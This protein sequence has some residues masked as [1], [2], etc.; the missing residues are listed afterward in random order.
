MRKTTR[1]SPALPSEWKRRRSLLHSE[2]W[3]W[4]RWRVDTGLYQPVLLFST[5]W[6]Q[7]DGDEVTVQKGLTGERLGNGVCLV[8]WL[9]WGGDGGDWNF[10]NNWSHLYKYSNDKSDKTDSF[11]LTLTLRICFKCAESHFL[12][13]PQHK[14]SGSRLNIRADFHL[15]RLKFSWSCTMCIIIRSS[16]C[17]SPWPAWKPDHLTR[18]HFLIQQSI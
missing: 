14:F 16:L 5:G 10:S 7:Q 3:W 4:W 1:F 9:E 17:V 15:R 13:T 6:E 2:A 12:V 8:G 11:H 18:T